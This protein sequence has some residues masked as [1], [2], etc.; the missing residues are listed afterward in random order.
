MAFTMKLTTPLGSLGRLNYIYNVSCGVGPNLPNLR[1][2]VELVQILLNHAGIGLTLSSGVP[3]GYL[4]INGY[5]D[6]HTRYSLQRLEKT[7]RMHHKVFKS[8]LH[9]HPSSHDGYTKSGEQYK[10][11]HLNRMVQDSDDTG[12][13]HRNLPYAA[14]IPAAL[15]GALMRDYSK[16]AGTSVSKKP[17]Y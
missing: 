7:L 16:A 5:L 12:N 17:A 10:I 14:E 1:E 3:V 2:D 6:E 8:D 11:V 4:N 9:I 15:K 13:R